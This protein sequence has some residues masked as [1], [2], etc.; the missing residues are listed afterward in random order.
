[1]HAQARMRALNAAAAQLAAVSRMKRGLAV[2]RAEAACLAQ[3]AAEDAAAA[4]H[5]LFLQ[6]TGGP[7]CLSTCET[8]V[9]RSMKI[10]SY[11]GSDI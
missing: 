6:R 7:Y 4:L 2:W 8:S 3:H 5:H 9:Q 10:Q 11:Q 1:M